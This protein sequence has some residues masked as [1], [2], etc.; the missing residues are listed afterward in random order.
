MS[1]LGRPFTAAGTLTPLQLSP[2][3]R[4]LQNVITRRLF[5]SSLALFA[6]DDKARAD[7]EKWLGLVDSA[8]CKDS[9][10][11]ASK[12]FRTQVT[13]EEW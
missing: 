3:P 5:L 12:P 6:Q 9:W 2:R 4:T 1:I 13:A 11:E 10:K 8:K 7:A